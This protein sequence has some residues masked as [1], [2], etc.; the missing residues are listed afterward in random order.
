MHKV[1]P[2]C[3]LCW[4]REEGYFVGAMYVSYALAIAFLLALM[5]VCHLLLPHLSSIWIATL[6]IVLFVPFVPMVF[7]YSRVIWLYFDHWAWPENTSD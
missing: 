1:C 7:R 2:V 3:G 5:L 6:A 4:E